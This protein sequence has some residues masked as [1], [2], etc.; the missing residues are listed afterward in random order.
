MSFYIAASAWIYW[1]LCYIKYHT[2]KFRDWFNSIFKVPNLTYYV[3]SLVINLS[4]HSQLKRQE[5]MMRK[6]QRIDNIYIT[7]HS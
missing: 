5:I 7:D 3:M 2:N 4:W 6:R 1:T